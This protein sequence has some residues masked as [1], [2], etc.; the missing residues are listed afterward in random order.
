M[1]RI[2][3]LIRWPILFGLVAIAITVIS[4]PVAAQAGL[5]LAYPPNNHKTTSD[6]IFLIG[7]A[8]ATNEVTVNE[9]PVGDRSP[10]GHFAPS[11]PLQ[12]GTNTL[13][14]KASS[15]TIQLQVERSQVQT[16]P[17]TGLAFGKDSLTPAVN[18]S[19]LPNEPICLQAIAS[20]QAQVSA[21]L[22]TI[23]LPLKPASQA[24]N[25]PANSA[26][27]TGKNQSVAERASGLFKG[28]TAIASPGNLG[29]PQ[30]QL[31]LNGQTLAQAA[32]GQLTILNPAQFSIVEVT[33]AQGGT[34]RTG[35]S[36]DY[37]RLTPLPSGTRSRVTAQSGE[38][39]RLDYGGWIRQSETRPLAMSVPVES[40]IRS[41]SSRQVTGWTEVRF[42]L[43]MPVPLRVDQGEQT[44]TLTLY[45]T[46]AQTDL[47]RLDDDPVIQRLDWQQTAPGQVQY[48][49]NLKARQQWGYKLRYEGA[50]LVLSLRHPPALSSQGP[51][52]QGITIVLDPGHGGPIDAG[53]VGP[54]GYPEKS[55]TLF[56]GKRLEQALT[57]RGAKVVMTRTEDVDLDLQPRVD[58]I[59]QAEPAIALSLHFNA[60]PDSGDALNAK[61]VGAFWYQGQSHDL[62]LFLQHYLVSRLQRPSYGLFWDNLALTRPAVAPAILLELG[63][64]INPQEFEWI[65]DPKAQQK[66]A[67]TLADGITD[68]LR[69]SNDRISEI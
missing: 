4:Q 38:W 33:T 43:E 65:A 37:S 10:S 23:E 46:T 59:T 9:Q 66:L 56:V 22:G 30:F 51:P 36:T 45:N 2:L 49:F 32:P 63:F 31:S 27:L 28:C 53:S 13:V 64:M 67:V 55:A 60:L 6:R 11:F 68:W 26:L 41:L 16:Q 62:A 42:P 19:L 29:H 15:Q 50:T 3:N 61:G 52:L 25:L 57:Q 44:F 24:V 8:P 7:S 5:T 40:I 17:P 21:K 69:H 47:I 18:M 1:Q 35:P 12:V 34:A 48:R 58:V 54:T 39:F 20:P 14:V